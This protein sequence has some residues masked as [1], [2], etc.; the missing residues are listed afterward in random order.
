MALQS[1][2]KKKCLTFSLAKIEHQKEVQKI[3]QLNQL[4]FN[5]LRKFDTAMKHFIKS[6]PYYF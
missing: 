6:F 1:V 5:I 4:I 2:F 3:I